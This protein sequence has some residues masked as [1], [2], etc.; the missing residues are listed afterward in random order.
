M[1]RRFC[2][3]AWLN[4]KVNQG[5]LD[6]TEFLAYRV[7]ISITTLI[8]YCLIANH[9]T[10]QIDL[11]RWVVGNAFA[12]CIY[13][14]IFGLGICFNSDRYYGRLR[15]I[16]V[17]PTSKLTVIMY[18]GVYSI[19]IAFLTIVVS[20]ATGGLIFG[21][22]FN[23]LNLGMLMLAISIAVFTCVGF[24]FLF[25][26]LALITD[27][28]YLLLNAI[29]LLIIIFSGANFPV[30]QLPAFA[31][32]IAHIF[33]LFRSVQAANMSFGGEFSSLFGQLLIGEAILGLVFYV[34]SFILI[35]IIERIAIKRATLEIF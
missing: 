35:K 6:L 23:D 21:I 10:G 32:W 25:A 9:A 17:S 1:I 19:F 27:S 3:Q 24:G 8:F 15:S 13:E 33:P 26:V 14:C 7:G 5:G 12:L 22:P 16:I 30:S 34:M 2:S 18:Y 11:T 4:A 31:Q 29:G 28:I 20:F